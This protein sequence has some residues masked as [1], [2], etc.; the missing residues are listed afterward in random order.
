MCVTKQPF[1]TGYRMQTP[2]KD[3]KNMT[4]KCTCRET[5]VCLG[6]E[7]AKWQVQIIQPVEIGR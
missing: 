3:I 7:I 1:I 4:Y 6:Q 5:V 2:E